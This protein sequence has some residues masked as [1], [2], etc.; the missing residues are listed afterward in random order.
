MGGFGRNETDGELM[1]QNLKDK[2]VAILATD[3]V[4][5]SEL[6]E[7]R[8]AL[9][10]A[11]LKTE[12]IS[13]HSGSIKAWKDNNWGESIPV[14]RV[15]EDAHAS[16]YA[17]LMLPGGVKNPDTLR[18]SPKAVDFVRAFAR[19]GKP[20]AAIC[21]GPWLLAEADVLKGRTVTSWASIK[22]DLV[23]AGAHWVDSEVVSDGRLITSRQPSDIP[24]FSE[25]F[26]E[27]LR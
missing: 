21:H 19:E 4:E 14:D 16:S 26:L 1:K 22:K 6:L 11:G 15:V 3:G 7:P 2:T 27:E 13:L 18:M 20:I 24:A 23:N 8:K 12:L 10:L 25:K 5:Q 17:A 9:E